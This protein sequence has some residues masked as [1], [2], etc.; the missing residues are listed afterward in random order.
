MQMGVRNYTC[1]MEDGN[2]ILRN[3]NIP[4]LTNQSTIIYFV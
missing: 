4:I 2:R 1:Y 3:M